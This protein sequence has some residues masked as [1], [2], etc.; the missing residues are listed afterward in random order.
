MNSLFQALSRGGGGGAFGERQASK[1]KMRRSDSPVFF[2]H[3]CFRPLPPTESLE[4]ATV[5]IATFS[6]ERYLIYTTTVQ[7]LHEDSDP[8]PCSCLVGNM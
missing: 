5:C 3:R 1:E 4:Q 6:D 2:T 7:V 8:Q